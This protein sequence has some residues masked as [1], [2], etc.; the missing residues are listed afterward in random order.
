M[1]PSSIYELEDRTTRER[2][3]QYR[4][5]DISDH[6]ISTAASGQLVPAVAVRRERHARLQRSTTGNL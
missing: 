5:S 1:G 6:A 2:Q 3:R 4:T